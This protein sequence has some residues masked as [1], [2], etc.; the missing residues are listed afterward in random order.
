MT[1]TFRALRSFGGG[2]LR[3]ALHCCRLVISELDDAGAIAA[4]TCTPP[5]IRASLQAALIISCSV[6][7]SGP[8]GTGGITCDGIRVNRS[9]AAVESS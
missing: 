5:V 1:E 6:S 2:G 7:Y 3:V 9:S 4:P 8:Y